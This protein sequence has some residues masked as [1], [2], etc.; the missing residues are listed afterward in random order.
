NQGVMRNPHVERYWSH[1][2]YISPIELKT[3]DQDAGPML[4]KG[5]SGTVAGQA[6]TF[7]DFEREGVMG[8]PNGFTVRARVRVGGAV[9]RPGIKIVPGYGITKLPADLPGGGTIT[10]GT[11]NPNAGTAQFSIAGAPGAGAAAAPEVLAVEISTK[12]LIGLVW[13]GMGILLF[14]ALLG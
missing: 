14:G 6:V 13:V 2:V 8:D 10:L 3:P 9:V 11:V 7:E 12:P 4:A 1:D 5:E